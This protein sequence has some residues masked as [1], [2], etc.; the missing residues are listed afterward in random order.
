M[1][2]TGRE[3][4]S[5]GNVSDP[6]NESYSVPDA[7]HTGTRAYTRSYKYDKLGNMLDLYHD[8]TIAN[9]FHR[10]F[11][12]WNNVGSTAYQLSN[13]A[14]EINFGGT[15][16][17]YTF[18]DNGNM[19][20]E[21]AGRSFEWDYGDRMRGFSEGTTTAAYLYDAGG[22]RVKKVVRKSSSLKE[23]TVYIDGGFEYIYKLDSSNVRDEEFNEVHVMDGRSRVAR[24]KVFGTTWSGS[25]WDAKVYNLEDHLGNSTFSV[26]ANSSLINREEYFPFGETSFGS[27]AIKRYRYN[28]KERDEESGLYYYGARYYAC[29][30]CR[31]VSID[32]LAGEMPFATP[33]SYAANNPVVLV[34]VD[35]L[36]PEGGTHQQ[37]KQG[38]SNSPQPNG[39]QG[40][41]HSGLPNPNAS[42]PNFLD[43]TVWNELS[44][45]QVIGTEAKTQGSNQSSIPSPAAKP[46]LA[47]FQPRPFPGQPNL[48][49]DPPSPFVEPPGIETPGPGGLR[50]LVPGALGTAALTIA[51]VL[52]PSGS[53]ST[54]NQVPRY[55]PQFVP[56]EPPVQPPDSIKVPEREDGGKTIALGDGAMLP[57]FTPEHGLPY[58][59]WDSGYNFKDGQITQ[60]GIN[61]DPIIFDMALLKLISDPKVKFNFLLSLSWFDE[62][63][64]RAVLNS[65]S[66]PSVR[67]HA[68]KNSLSTK[69]VICEE[70]GVMKALQQEQPER[71]T[72]WLLTVSNGYMI[73]KIQ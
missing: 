24:V 44:R 39:P 16:V 57:D 53:S 72:F 49:I 59:H 21:G 42:S 26:D 30:S 13:L 66:L 3:S 4:G 62:N 71:V 20:S 5:F 43:G 2:A 64:K 46:G 17:S 11:N 6:W 23:V 25:Q 52:I 10:V 67:S 27:Y 33:F 19:L 37:S 65:S 41:G 58:Y 40:E 63:G 48:P 61:S 56:H 60:E 12:D 70:Y 14:T 54:N 18:D 8:G 73:A 55:E 50:W 35:G 45:P 34:D 9:R 28:G 36:A 51:I 32:P 38:P 7:S 47:P 1:L 31:F 69:C 29:W 68:L 22:N 15:T